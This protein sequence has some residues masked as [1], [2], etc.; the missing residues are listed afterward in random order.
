MKKRSILLSLISIVMFSHSLMHSMQIGNIEIQEQRLP[1][2][3]AA[4]CGGIYFLGM[5][6]L[7]YR[8]YK[9]GEPVISLSDQLKPREYEL[10]QL[11]N[12]FGGT[13]V[14]ALVGGGLG[15]AA[16]KITSLYQKY[17][18]KMFALPIAFLAGYFSRRR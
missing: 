7:M 16:T 5:G 13:V 1:A 2:V 17:D 6:S 9:K 3:V 4:V 14:T 15:W 11:R 10:G 8:D 18:P 12:L